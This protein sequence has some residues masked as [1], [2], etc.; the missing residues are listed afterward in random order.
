M[1][2]LLRAGIRNG[3]RR[4]V[5]GGNQAWVVIGGVALLGHLGRR[6]LKRTDDVLWAGQVAP[7]QVLTVQHV[8]EA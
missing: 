7:G 1:N 6:A 8:T 2:W 5:L 4:G 3:W